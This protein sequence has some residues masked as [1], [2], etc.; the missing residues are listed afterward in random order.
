MRRGSV[1]ISIHRHLTIRSSRPHVVA[2]AVRFTLRLHTSAAPP[3]VGLTQALGPAVQNLAFETLSQVAVIAASSSTPEEYE[4][5]AFSL[6][7]NSE[8]TRRA[9]DWLPEAFGIVLVSHMELGITLPQSFMAR[10]H[11][12]VWLEFPLDSDPI[13][14]DSLKLATTVFHNGPRDVFSA[15]ATASSIVDTVNQTLNSGGSLAGAVFQP[16]RMHGLSAEAYGG[17]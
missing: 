11:A 13:F 4:A 15:L 12:G 1:H 14:A 5:A 3:R 17:T 6:I 8:L 16:I 9:L 7:G 2:S 10:N